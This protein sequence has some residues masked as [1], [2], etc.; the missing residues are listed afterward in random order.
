MMVPFDEEPYLLVPVIAKLR[1]T[2]YCAWRW[3]R[4]LPHYSLFCPIPSVYTKEQALPYIS[5]VVSFPYSRP[6][7]SQPSF[8]L[9][10]VQD[11]TERQFF[12]ADCDHELQD[13]TQLLLNY[14]AFY[15]LRRANFGTILL[16]SLISSPDHGIGSI[17]ISR[18]RISPRSISRKRSGST[19]TTALVSLSRGRLVRTIYKVN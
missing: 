4:H 16:P 2:N 14:S 15:H 3:R 13:L 11:K 6:R 5:S 19:T 1:L 10:P 8:I 7:S 12:L 17:I 9:L 18:R